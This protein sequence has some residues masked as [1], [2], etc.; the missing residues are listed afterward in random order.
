MNAFKS[1]KLHSKHYNLIQTALSLLKKVMH[2]SN[3]ILDFF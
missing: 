2:W 3:R 1:G